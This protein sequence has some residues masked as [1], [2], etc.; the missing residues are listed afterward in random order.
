M[1]PPRGEEEGTPAPAARRR[2]LLDD[3]LSATRRPLDLERA[4]AAVKLRCA[5]EVFCEKNEWAR[6][7]PRLPKRGAARRRFAELAA[8]SADELIADVQAHPEHYTRTQ[9]TDLAQHHLLTALNIDVELYKQGLHKAGLYEGLHSVAGR[10]TTLAAAAATGGV[11]T[12]PGAEHALKAAKKAIKVLAH[13]LPPNI[14]NPALTGTLRSVTDVKEAFKRVGGQPVVAPQIER[15]PDLATIVRSLRTQRGELTNATNQ[16]REAA[17]SDAVGAEAIGPMIDAF[18]ALHD[19]ADR[20]YR[21]RIGLNRTQTYSKGWG[22]AVN[23][24]GVAGTVVTATVPVVGQIAGPAILAATVPMQWGAGYLDE[25]RNKHRYNLRANTK[26]GDFLTAGAARI[27]FKDL[28]PEHVSEAALRR[29]F[30]TQPEVQIAAVREVYEDALGE[31]VQQHAELERKVGAM[32]SSGTTPVRALMPHRA[33]LAQLTEQIELAKQHAAQFESLDPAQW[34]AIPQDSL[35]GRCLD[36]LKQLEKANRRA[37]MR[38]PGESAQIVQRY[39]QAFHAGV[40]TGT[41]LPIMDAITATDSSYITDAQG[42]Q[43]HHLHPSDEAGTLTAGIGGGAVF[44]AATGEVR[45]TKADNK[46]VLSQ[47][48]VS[49]LQTRLHEARWV[50]EAG[51]RRVDLRTTAGYRKHVHSTWDE[52]RLLGRAVRHGLVSGPVGLTNLVRAKWWPRGELRLAKRQ[53]RDTLDALGQAGLQRNPPPDAR[54]AN[55][56]SAMKDELYD[57]AA[58][59]RHLGVETA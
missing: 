23:G 22:M 41:A 8:V 33:Q 2:Q 32:E 31:W 53:L 18:L 58:V 6:F 56:I 27:H 46:K 28:R 15:S 36:D 51:N 44:T 50:F 11:S 4:L 5:A 1:A 55:T 42:H 17:Q 16:F 38:K 26:W 12:I 40:S 13:E 14:V 47:T 10:V 7:A 52:L 48:H 39:V 57:Y 35:I 9:L 24:V 19:T 37:R 3:Y 43:T 20:Q 49:P 45:M 29:S 34:A 21:R 30:M 25:R 54:R 59:R